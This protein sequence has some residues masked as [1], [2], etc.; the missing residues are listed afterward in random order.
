MTTIRQ[1]R[2]LVAPSLEADGRLMSLES[3]VILKPASRIIRFVLIDRASNALRFEPRWAI[4]PLC[5]P[6]DY[7]GLAWGELIYPP[8]AVQWKWDDPGAPAAFTDEVQKR[9]VPLLRQV[10]NLDDFVKF[11]NKER[12]PL[13]PFSAFDLKTPYVDAAL[14]SFQSALATCEKL[15]T[16]RSRYCSADLAPERG[17]ILDELRPLLLA[18]DR[19]GLSRFLHD[20]EATSVRNL[21]LEHIWERSPFP[22]ELETVLR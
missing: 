17:K 21:K 20:C 22:F 13:A 14:G 4:F 12:F 15:A 5:V 7:F 6:V 2:M 3:K 18:N 16:G 11:A 9:I 8:P 19:A 1:I 10:R